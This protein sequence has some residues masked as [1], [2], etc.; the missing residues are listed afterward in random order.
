MVKCQHDLAFWEY[1]P[2]FGPH[3]MNKAIDTHIA[4]VVNRYATQKLY[5]FSRKV[6]GMEEREAMLVNLASKSAIQSG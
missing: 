3:I 4:A 2:S 6:T 1:S 5:V